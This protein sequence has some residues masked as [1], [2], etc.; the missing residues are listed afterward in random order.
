MV[1]PKNE[2]PSQEV[3]PELLTGEDNGQELPF[4]GRVIFLRGRKGSTEI[5]NRFFGP[6]FLL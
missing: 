2:R 6:I 3:D 1:R 4:V 5:G